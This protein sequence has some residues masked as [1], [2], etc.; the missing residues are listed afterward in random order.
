MSDALARA[1]RNNPTLNQQRAGVRATD[2]T[3]SQ[4]TAAYR[5]TVS[6]TGQYGVTHLAEVVPAGDS[7][8]LGAAGG[9]GSGSTTLSNLTEPAAVNLTVTQT[10]FNG[11]RNVNGVR[12]AESNVFGA[13]EGLRNTEE[14]V[15][16]KLGDGG[17]EIDGGESIRLSAAMVD[18]N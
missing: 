16:M 6:M 8:A 14:T 17:V 13:R 2:E 3:V 18:L 10:I 11:N 7:A 1:Y 15:T 9:G 12:K 4:A 5:P